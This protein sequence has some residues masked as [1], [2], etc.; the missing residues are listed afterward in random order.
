MF[1]D[2]IPRDYRKE[3]ILGGSES[4]TFGNRSA[5]VGKPPMWIGG[6][7][8]LQSSIKEGNKVLVE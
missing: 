7:L 2:R 1:D 6:G 8:C 3:V 4:L 5:I